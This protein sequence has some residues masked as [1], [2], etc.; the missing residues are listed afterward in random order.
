M[1]SLVLVNGPCESRT[2]RNLGNQS[3][4]EAQ[5][6]LLTAAPSGRKV[7]APKVKDRSWPDGRKDRRS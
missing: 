7:A 3:M 4:T 5:A 1:F 6:E 2:N